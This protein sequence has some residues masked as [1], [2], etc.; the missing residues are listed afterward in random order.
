MRRKPSAEKAR[1]RRICRS[2]ALNSDVSRDWRAN[3]HQARSTSFNPEQ[4]KSILEEVKTVLRSS[5][6]PDFGG[7]GPT[8]MFE[9]LSNIA[10]LFMHDAEECC[11][12]LFVR[13][14]PKRKCEALVLLRGIAGNRLLRNLNVRL[15][16][17]LKVVHFEPLATA[18]LPQ[19]LRMDE[20]EERIK[21]ARLPP[22]S[23][24]IGPS[25]PSPSA[26]TAH[27]RKAIAR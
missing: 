17:C 26:P 27:G 14:W 18:E 4:A 21:D 16:P 20:E 9:I 10:P 13:F 24:Y 25:P 11:I 12:Q 5:D 7:L 19:D 8:E 3:L 22:G 15:L 23:T 2:H 1:F 6:Y